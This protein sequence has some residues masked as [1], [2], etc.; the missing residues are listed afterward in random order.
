MALITNVFRRRGTYYFR[1]RV[2]VHLQAVVGR[3]ELWRSLK[4][5]RPEDARRRGLAVGRLTERLWRDV[6]RAMLTTASVDKGAI[7][8]LIDAWLRAEIEEDTYLRDAPD[9]EKH[10][11]VMLRR[12]PAHSPDS[13]VRY[14]DHGALEAFRSAD[15]DEQR[16][17]LGPDGYLLEGV[18]DLELARAGQRKVLD[19][20]DAR[21]A[22]EDES[23]AAELVRQVFSRRGVPVDEFSPAFELATR[24]M[25]RAQYDLLRI[26]GLRDDAKWRPLLDDDPAE[27]LISKLGPPMDPQPVLGTV[28]AGASHGM[29]GTFSALARDAIDEL[30]R[31]RDF[32]PKRRRDYENAVDTFVAWRGSDPLLSELTAELFGRYKSDLTY[33]PSNAHKRPAYRDL[34]VGDCIRKARESGETEVLEPVTADGKYIRPLA[35]ILDWAKKSGRWTGENPLAN[36]RVELPRK[37]KAQNR[38]RDFTDAEVARLLALPL[39]TGSAGLKFKKLY[40]PG[41]YR[42]RDWR[43]WVPLICLFSGMRLNEAC[44]L[45]LADVRDEAEPAYIAV[46]DLGPDQSLKSDAAW[47]KVPIHEALIK[48]GFLRFV[49]E[50]RASSGT[51]L[52]DDLEPDESGYLSNKPS[53]FLN[54]LVARIADPDPELRGKLVFHSSRHTVIG[55]LRAAG[56][57]EDVA[58]QIVGHE[59]GTTHAGYGGY[60]VKALKREL[61][62]VTYQG[63]NLEA[64]RHRPT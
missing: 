19:G 55:K 5:G 54:D 29:R 44:G 61:D 36:I 57:R 30:A 42:V 48:L 52:F 26:V 28:A 9:G 16:A 49:A 4:T 31:A 33:Y 60:D 20:A 21:H 8:A 7:K 3:K 17:I 12:E 46:R 27:A 50:R 64:L 15:R 18:T 63:M 22:A 32:K 2:P 41:P 11:A 39:F 47:R 56:V 34:S 6:E 13:I 45:T 38:R 62:K 25:I 37:P 51:R 1:A 58:Y 10:V 24:L 59:Q 14:M 35:T 40:E 23:I 43:F 53:K